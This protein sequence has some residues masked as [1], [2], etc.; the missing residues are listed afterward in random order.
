MSYNAGK[1]RKAYE[2]YL[3]ELGTPDADLYSNGGRVPDGAKYGA[4][5][6]R[7]D[8]IAFNVG[9]NEWIYKH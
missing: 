4:W 9:Y 6:R 8:P 1:T 7:N 5:L 2:E 3:N